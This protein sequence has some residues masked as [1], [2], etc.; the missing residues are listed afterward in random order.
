MFMI[1]ANVKGKTTRFQAHQIR[2]M[3]EESDKRI[4]KLFCDTATGQKTFD[5]S[6]GGAGVVTVS[7]GGALVANYT[8]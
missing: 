2:L 7:F 5:V 1:E 4:G 6:R 3:A 8:V